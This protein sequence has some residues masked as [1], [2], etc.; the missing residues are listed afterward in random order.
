MDRVD[1]HRKKVAV[2]CQHNVDGTMIPIKFKIEDE[3]QIMQTYLIKGYRVVSEPGAYTMPNHVNVT[4][5][6][7]IFECKITVLGIEKT[8]RLFYF[9]RTGHWE[10]QFQM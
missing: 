10:A 2:I 1:T 6:F 8:I 7:R 4:S 3:D 5:A 9:I